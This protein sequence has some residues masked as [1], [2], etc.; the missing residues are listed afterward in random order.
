MDCDLR[1]ESSTLA[2]ELNCINI[3]VGYELALTIGMTLTSQ[4]LLDYQYMSKKNMFNEHYRDLLFILNQI[5]HRHNVKEKQSTKCQVRGI[6]MP[7]KGR[8]QQRFILP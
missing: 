6:P 2:H 5:T 4:Y 3:L 1:K 8:T 7:F